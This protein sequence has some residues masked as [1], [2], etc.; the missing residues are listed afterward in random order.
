MPISPNAAFGSKSEV[1]ARYHEVRFASEA[2]H[3]LN[4]RRHLRRDAD[5]AK[6]SGPAVPNRDP[7]ILDYFPKKAKNNLTRSTKGQLTTAWRH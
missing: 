7:P 6:V 2:E 3:R 1:T 5:G 4:A